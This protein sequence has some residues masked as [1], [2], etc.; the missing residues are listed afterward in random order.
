MSSQPSYNTEQMHCSKTVI[1]LS[2]KY[3]FYKVNV[4][5]KSNHKQ[6]Y[7]PLL[8]KEDHGTKFQAGLGVMEVHFI[9]HTPVIVVGKVCLQGTYVHSPRGRQNIIVVQRDK[10]W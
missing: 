3:E 9:G 8:C 7:I 10:L 5:V 1:G 6:G 4:E 2:S